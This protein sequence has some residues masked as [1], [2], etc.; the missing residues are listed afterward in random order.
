MIQ[1]ECILNRYL[2]QNKSAKDSKKKV[3]GKGFDEILEKELKNAENNKNS[4]S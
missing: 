4:R 3:L 1:T 2:K